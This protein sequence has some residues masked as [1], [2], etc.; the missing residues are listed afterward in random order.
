MV[1]ITRVQC[2]EWRDGYADADVI[3][4]VSTGDG[5]CMVC[6]WSSLV[7]IGAERV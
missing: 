2:E 6:V 1:G 4:D 7:C 3:V 5:L